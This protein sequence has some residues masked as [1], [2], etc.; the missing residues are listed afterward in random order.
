MMIQFFIFVIIFIVSSLQVMGGIQKE[1]SYSIGSSA[2]SEY[3]SKKENPSNKD[4]KKEGKAEAIKN[5]ELSDQLQKIEEKVKASAGED[6]LIQSLLKEN[7]SLKNNLE[8]RS[9]DA[10]LCFCKYHERES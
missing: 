5:A 9:C 10:T 3:N 8:D 2:N 7:K 1:R 4:E 6:Q